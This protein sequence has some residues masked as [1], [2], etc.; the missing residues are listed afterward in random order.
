MNHVLIASSFSCYI[1]YALQKN[2]KKTHNANTN[3]QN[4]S[5]L[6]AKSSK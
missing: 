1:S 2:Q 4:I 3:A 5:P 6:G